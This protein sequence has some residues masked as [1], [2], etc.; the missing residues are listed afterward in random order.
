[1]SIIKRGKTKWT[2]EVIADDDAADHDI[3]VDIEAKAYGLEVEGW[4]I[5]WGEVREAA[6]ACGVVSFEDETIAAYLVAL[7]VDLEAI[8]K[9][10][11][12]GYDYIDIVLSDR[13]GSSLSFEAS[14]LKHL[15]ALNLEAEADA[16]DEERYLQAREEAKDAIALANDWA[17]RCNAETQR[18]FTEK[19]RADGLATELACLQDPVNMAA[20]AEAN[21]Y[22][23]GEGVTDKQLIALNVIKNQWGIDVKARCLELYG[24][25]TERLLRTEASEFLERL[26]GEFND[27]V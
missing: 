21:G 9:L 3:T 6:E 14:W 15:A 17:T 8:G 10:P 18:W 26:K 7:G 4:V 22:V 27:K 19:Q 24:C 25:D 13:D 11:M 23:K 1:M 2:Y 16:R 12:Q 5:P 20:W